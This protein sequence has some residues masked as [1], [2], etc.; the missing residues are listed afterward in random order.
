MNPIS[1]QELNIL[2]KKCIEDNFSS[3]Y[4]VIAEISEMRIN[5]KGHCYLELVEKKED[6]IL[7]KIRATIWSYSYRNLSAWFEAVT[8]ESLKQ[9][10]KIL[11]NVMVSFHEVFGLSLN[12]RDIDPNYTIGERARRKQEILAKLKEDGVLE[13]NKELPLPTVPQRIALIASPTSAGYQ[14]FLDQLEKNIYDYRFQIILFQAIMQGKE[15][16]KSIIDAMLIANRTIE[17]F[18]LLVI[19]RG[20]GASLDLE[21]FDSYGLASHVAQFPIPVITGICH[22]RDET[23]TDL[24]ANSKLKTPTAVAEFLIAGCR[25]FDEK[26]EELFD[27]IAE[28][29]KR[30]IQ[31]ERYLIDDISQKLRFTTLSIFDRHSYVFRQTS[32]KFRYG[33]EKKI[34]LIESGMDKYKNS[35]INSVRHILSQQKNRIDHLDSKLILLSP[36]MIL[37][38]GFSITR[39]N[40]QVIKD[41]GE[42][43][44]DDIIETEF[45]TG[46]VKSKIL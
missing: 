25:Q 8:G 16:E 41:K 23:I 26:I 3:S 21:C 46:K 14:D 6:E 42:L 30:T 35:I 22:E 19:I 2:I 17:N 12:I 32:E 1:L 44:A 13:M 33:L 7:A 31:E 18:D 11:A 20:G 24:V 36:E 45:S 37:N 39:K 29:A 9:G 43:S 15:A 5:Q 4:W 40:N 28:Y 10:L 38:R 34:R 27:G